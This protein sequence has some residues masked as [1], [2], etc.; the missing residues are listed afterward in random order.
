MTTHPMIIF[1][2]QHKWRHLRLFRRTG[3]VLTD[4]RIIQNYARRLK[5]EEEKC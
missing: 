2:L 4:Y 1:A 3:S 5:K